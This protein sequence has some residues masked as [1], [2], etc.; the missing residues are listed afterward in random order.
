[1]TTIYMV[2]IIIVS[3]VF[4]VWVADPHFV[5]GLWPKYRRFVGGVWVLVAGQW[6]RPEERQMLSVVVLQQLKRD[7]MIEAFEDHR[8]RV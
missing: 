6:K 7:C 4:S 1:M 5:F 3:L 2:S 8:K